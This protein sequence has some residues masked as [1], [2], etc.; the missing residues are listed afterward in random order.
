VPRMVRYDSRLERPKLTESARSESNDH[1]ESLFGGIVVCFSFDVR[2][3]AVGAGLKGRFR[4]YL[5][6]AAG[7]GNGGFVP[8]WF[9]QES[10]AISSRW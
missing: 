10:Q 3:H 1:I 9:G 2:G 7:S 5:S 4:W 6:C 8:N